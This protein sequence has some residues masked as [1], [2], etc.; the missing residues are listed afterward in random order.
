MPGMRNVT[1]RQL[2]IFVAAADSLSFSRASAQLHL[3]QP[4]VSMQIRQLEH[5]AGLPLF[6]RLGKRLHLTQAGE[7]LLGYA[8]QALRALKEADDAFAALQGPARGPAAHR[9]GEHGQVLRAQAAGAVRAQPS[10]D[11]AQAG[12]EQPRG[13]GAPARLERDR[14]GRHGAA[15]APPG[16]RGC[17]FRAPP[18]RHH[19]GARPS[20]GLAQAHPPA[21]AG[22]RDLP[23]ARARA[24]GR[25]PRWSTTSR[26]RACGCGW[27]WR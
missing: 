6:E 10:G 22:E 15:A 25:A 16:N 1:L 4:A 14:P 27:A 13:G 9:R 7:E 23:G 20:A 8:R 26:S 19:R 2:Q 21:R 3:T 5:S 18:A 11:R 12:G 17:A 24:P